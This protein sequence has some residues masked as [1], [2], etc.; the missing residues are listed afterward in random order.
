VNFSTDQIHSIVQKVVANIVEQGAVKEEIIKRA[1]DTKVGVFEDIN[2][3]IDA[4]NQA[5]LEFQ[6]HDI[7]DRRK[8]T[9]AIRQMT[10]DHK[11]EL[12]RMTVEETKMGRVEHKILKH[13]NA[14]KNSP[15]VEFLQPQAW[16]GK[17][18]QAVDEYAPF[19]VI[20]NIT[21]S[22]HPGPVMVNNMIIQLAAGNTIVFNQHPSTKKVGGYIVQLANEYMI[23]EGAPVNLV[24]CVANPTLETAK[25][26]FGHPNIALLAVTGGPVM[27]DL[28]MKYPKKI[29]AAGPGNP[30][31]LIDETADLDLAA[32][33]ITASSSYDNNVLC[34]AEKEI[35][36]VDRVF[37]AFLQ[38]FEIEGNIRL[39]QTQ[40]NSLADKALIKEGKHYFIHPDFIGRNASELAKTL[41]IQINEEVPMLFGE[42]DGE[43]PWVVAEQMTSCIP[44]VRVKNFDEGVIAALKAE[45]GFRHS[46]SIFTQDMARAT[47][48]AKRF[49]GNVTVVN[50]GTWRGNGSDLGEGYFSH[51][52]A[53]PTGEGI[54]TPLDFC[55]KR[56]IMV[57]GALRYV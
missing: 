48:F 49:G 4:A 20:G 45:H 6:D 30:P 7:Q 3:A 47:I 13:I 1:P 44:V 34:T 11:E 16:S 31:V 19:G 9:D 57:T 21:P 15:G 24:T 53:S 28:A 43:H 39:T 29:I 10:Y 12:S 36:I 14:A 27:V 33:E 26:L 55:R 32:R 52:I 35:F 5:F 50:G 22:T 37:E 54:C 41:G 25:I 18:G 8:Y 2:T 51:T 17:N 56:R 38:A 42:T 40:M 23:K 46:A